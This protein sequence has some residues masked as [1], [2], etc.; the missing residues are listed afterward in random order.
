[1]IIDPDYVIVSRSPLTISKIAPLFSKGTHV[2]T[3]MFT[4]SEEH[5]IDEEKNKIATMLSNYEKKHA[6]WSRQ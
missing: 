4:T 6:R 5:I 3:M 2:Q 1:M